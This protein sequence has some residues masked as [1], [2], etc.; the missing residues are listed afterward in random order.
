MSTLIS[1]FTQLGPNEG[2]IW[3]VV[4]LECPRHVYVHG[5]CLPQ[6]P[7]LSQASCPNLLHIACLCQQYFRV[8]SFHE[9]LV[10]ASCGIGI[11]IFWIGG[12]YCYTTSM[13]EEPF[14]YGAR[15]MITCICFYPCV[16]VC[17]NHWYVHVLVCWWPL[18]LSDA[19]TFVGGLI[20]HPQ[21]LGV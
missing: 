2:W 16:C 11:G 5:K 6:A 12:M 1:P 9:R 7:W 4:S 20:L 19:N 17:G 8:S 10:C 15:H 21:M 14:I 13:Y 18:H 3:A